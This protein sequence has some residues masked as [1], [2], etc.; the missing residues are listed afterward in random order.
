MQRFIELG[1]AKRNE[2]SLKSR[3][4]IEFGSEHYPWIVMLHISFFT[5]L[6]MEVMVTDKE[7]SILWPLWLTIF[8]IA[9]LGRIW[10]ILSLGKHWNT[11]ILVLPDAPLIVRGPYKYV[12]HPNYIIVAVEILVL[13]LLFNGYLTAIFFTILNIWMMSVR[14]PAEERALKQYIK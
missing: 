14:I 5:F 10:V 1:I 2:R 8:I 6:I 12:K 4:A 13:S 11:K 7:L 3:G 9:Q